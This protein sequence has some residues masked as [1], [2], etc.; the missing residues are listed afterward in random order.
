MPTGRVRWF[1]SQKGY[2]VIRPSTGGR[3]VKV[4]EEDLLDQERLS[5]GDKV[6]FELRETGHDR[7]AVDVRSVD[8][9]F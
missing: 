9:L 3:E 4:F 7:K 6:I 5:T 1:D 2:G 8:D